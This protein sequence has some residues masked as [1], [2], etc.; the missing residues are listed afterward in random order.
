MTSRQSARWDPGGN[1]AT[2]K[3]LRTSEQGTDFEIPP[4][5]WFSN[6]NGRT[7]LTHN[8]NYSATWLGVHGNRIPLL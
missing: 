2:G 6:C 3:E 8:I 4:W 1:K 7:G 5:H